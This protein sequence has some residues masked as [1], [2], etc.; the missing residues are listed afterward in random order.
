MIR[1]KNFLTIFLI[2]IFLNNCGFTPR[3]AINKNLGF[4]IDLTEISGDREFNN[5]LKTKLSRYTSKESDDKKNYKLNLKTEYKKNVKSRDAA[6][7]A[8]EYELIITV[9][10]LIKSEMMES[11]KIIFEEKFD[12]KKYEDAF[13]EK[14]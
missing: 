1:F 2:I 13:E 12:M 6:G 9:D 3:Y 4:S 7:L 11:K 14:N 5:F 8:E 10:A